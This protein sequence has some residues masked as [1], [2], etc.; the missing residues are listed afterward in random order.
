MPN[1]RV[2]FKSV[3]SQLFM[4]Q[5]TYGILAPVLRVKVLP[6]DMMEIDRGWNVGRR[7]EQMDEE[8]KR[9]GEEGRPL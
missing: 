4:P 9:T 2:L 8:R 6:R 1:P 3:S 5:M 7:E